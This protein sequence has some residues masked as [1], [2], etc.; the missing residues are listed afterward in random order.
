LLCDSGDSVPC[1]CHLAVESVCDTG[2]CGSGDG[3]YSISG[4]CEGG[5]IFVKCESDAG[6]CLCTAARCIIDSR[7]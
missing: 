1:L 2:D 7:S 4:N 5:K 3:G 6:W